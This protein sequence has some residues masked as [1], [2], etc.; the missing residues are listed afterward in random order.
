MGRA[1]A[2]LRGQRELSRE[3][4]AERV[5]LDRP[6]LEGIERGDVDADWGT[7][8]RLASALDV[9]LDALIERAEEL[10]PGPGGT[11]WRRW[12]REAQDERG[13]GG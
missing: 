2:A 7:L 1:I 6:S 12:T 10:A 3:Q 11:E 8:R 9:R 5:G 4:L 13:G